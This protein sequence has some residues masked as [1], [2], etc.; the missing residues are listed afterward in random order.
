MTDH[1]AIAQDQAMER[2]SVFQAVMRGQIDG[3]YRLACAVLNDPIEAQDAVQ[4][5]LV[6]AWRHWGSL[7]DAERVHAW[8]QRIVVN[9]CRQRL[10]APARRARLVDVAQISEPAGP[11]TT[12][13]SAEHDALRGALGRLT[14]DERL[15]LVLR[16]YADLTVDDIAERISSRP[17]T[18]KSRLH[19]AVRALRAAY[20]AAERTTVDQEERR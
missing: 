10:R 2:G 8:F 5:A 3:G 12:A 11:D 14:P 1:G 7:R 6:Q 9:E 15:V 4:D 13:S 17:G 16:F 19:H 20:D 18:V